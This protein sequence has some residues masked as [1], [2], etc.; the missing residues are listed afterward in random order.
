NDARK[1]VAECLG[2]A[3][4]EVM[5]TSCGTESDNNALLGIFDQLSIQKGSHIITTTVEHSA[6]RKTCQYLEKM[7]GAQVS[8]L[9]VDHLGRLDMDQYKKS[10]RKKTILVSIMAA[11]NETG[12]L[13]PI[14]E[15]CHIAHEKGVLFHT[16]AVQA[17]GK[18]PVNVQDL[19]VDLLS[20]SGHKIYAPKGVGALYIKKGIPCQAVIKG[21]TQEK[22]RRGGTENLASIVG[23]GVAMERIQKCLK[24]ETPIITKLR[25][26]FESNILKTVPNS[27]INGDAHHRVGNTSNICFRGVEGESVV[28][29]LDLKGISV[30]SGSACSSGSIEP[31]SVLLAMGL[32]REEA[33]ASIRF[34]F[35]KGNSQEDVCEALK[36]IPKVV[37]KLREYSPIQ[38]S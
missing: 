3:I 37:E 38:L 28:L 22:G 6:I 12:V 14:K 5:F 36:T 21:G 11:N 23:L 33:G 32:T 9:P 16:D 15:L 20:L 1:K 10:F 34:S 18:I 7:R 2:A 29:S 31:S 4:S 17:V 25:D 24:D 26:E 13:F 30:S 8:Y 35:G 27:H 19:D